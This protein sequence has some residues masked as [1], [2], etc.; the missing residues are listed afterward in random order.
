MDL[1]CNCITVDPVDRPSM[2]E[3]IRALDSYVDFRQKE[4]IAIGGFPEKIN[5]LK[6]GWKAVEDRAAKKGQ[7]VDPFLETLLRERLD[8]IE[9]MINIL[10]NEVVILRDTRERLIVSMVRLFLRM[11]KGDRFLSVTSPGV[12]QGSALGPDG[13][14]F[15]ASTLATC[16][17]ALVQRVFVISIQELGIPWAQALVSKLETVKDK[18]ASHLR[19]MIDA[20]VCQYSAA[21]Q[22]GDAHE[23]SREFRS[24]AQR[25]FSLV[26][27]SYKEASDELCKN[28][29]QTKEFE[30]PMSGTGV[31]VG[32]LVEGTLRSVRTIK[33]THPVSVF[34]YGKEELKNQ[35]LLLMTDMHGRN[36]PGVSPLAVPSEIALAETKPEL[37]GITVFKSVLGIP[38]DRIKNLEI[39]FRQSVNAGCWIE[40]LVS[41]LPAIEGDAP[42]ED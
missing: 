33:A 19:N 11:E 16:K 31:Y 9:W 24:E 3:V 39:V 10:G 5:A 15:T 38:E 12:W 1:I 42:S 8:E 37:K 27:R 26:M 13:R 28:R 4:L 30:N 20:A 34:Y 6:V 21:L 18:R 23:M 14:Y 36:S 35:Y 22:N 2:E 29:F 40:R 32:L 41:A 7:C 17:G 25:R